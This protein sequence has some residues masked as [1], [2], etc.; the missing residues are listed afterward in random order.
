MDETANTET[1]SAT[2]TVL[3]ATLTEE[4]GVPVVLLAEG[5][6][7]IL[8]GNLKARLEPRIKLA[9]DHSAPIEVTKESADSNRIADVQAPNVEEAA[10]LIKEVAPPDDRDYT[11]EYWTTAYEKPR[12]PYEEDRILW[13]AKI[14]DTAFYR[15]T[16][17]RSHA[18]HYL[19][20]RHPR[21]QAILKTAAEAI[22]DRKP[23]SV[24]YGGPFLCDLRE[25]AAK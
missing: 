25:P 17:E 5:G 3:P 1:K 10:E 9:L 7:L 11:A 14:P 15:V 16:M 23:V 21:L 24:L 18:I 2:V 13:I 20:D 8:P 12:R 19:H 4:N 22:R 6:K